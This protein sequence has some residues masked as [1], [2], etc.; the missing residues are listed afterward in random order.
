MEIVGS[1]IEKCQHGVYL[2]SPEEIR[3]DRARYCGICSPEMDTRETAR[4][5]K[6]TVQ[7]NPVLKHR[8]DATSCPACG[9]DTH[10]IEGRMWVC[11]D[12]RNEWKPPKFLR[13]SNAFVSIRRVES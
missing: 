6:P 8:Y 3:A 9:C 7:A 11:T 13:N 2:A 1:C 5:W 4:D 12:C 10:H